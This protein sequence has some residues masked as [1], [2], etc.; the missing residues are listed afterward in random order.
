MDIYEMSVS[1]L[2]HALDDK[3]VTSEELVLSYTKRITSLDQSK[4]GCHSVFCLNPEAIQIAKKLDRE[5]ENGQLRGELHGIPVLIKDNID[6]LPM[7]TT[8]G[9]IALEFNYPQ[10]DAFMVRQLIDSGAIILGKTNLTEF[11]NFMNNK[12]SNGYSSLGGQ[13]KMPYNE[14][15]DPLGSST[16][17]AVAVATSM[18][19][20]AIGTETSGSIISPAMRNGIVGL[21]PSMGIVSRSGIIPISST[22]DTA[23]PMGR[24]V[25]DVA[26]LLDAMVGEDANDEITMSSIIKPSY[27]HRLT[28]DNLRNAKVGICLD[29]MDELDEDRSEAF[30]T[31]MNRLEEF[32]ATLVPNITLPSPKGNFQIMKYEFKN[33]INH[34]L[35]Q[36]S[37]SNGVQSLSDIID[38]NVDHA[39]KALKFGQELLVDCER[40]VSGRLVEKEYWEAISERLLIQNELKNI[41]EKLEL[42][43]ILVAYY[44]VIGSYTG[45]PVLTLPVGLDKKGLPMG[46]FLLGK[47]FDDDQLLGYAYS[48]EKILPKRVP[49]KI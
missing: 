40:K 35:R 30:E 46:V 11:A 5:R 23:G 29:A 15:E 9:S 3:K 28:E 42:D 8:A 22:L 2:K 37:N 41:F 31:L 20:V 49:P 24:S 26:I 48:I 16:G 32:G 12:R 47:Q 14:E 38:F 1:R 39:D 7:A 13:V 27:T 4:D 25:K 19:P 43:F 10:K 36:T 18:C 17:S 6:S 44:N 34:Y 33:R 45:Y 21:K